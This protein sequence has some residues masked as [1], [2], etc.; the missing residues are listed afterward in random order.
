MPVV[1]ILVATPYQRRPEDT[2][3][4]WGQ[5]RMRPTSN[6]DGKCGPMETYFP[7]KSKPEL[8]DELAA[9]LIADGA[10][11]PAESEPVKFVT[12]EEILRVD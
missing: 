9:K 4:C 2:P 6:P 1:K 5:L 10:A 3:R 8:S 12:M 11:E 7:A